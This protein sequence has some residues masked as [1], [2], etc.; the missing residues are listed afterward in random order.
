MDVF[1]RML[2]TDAEIKSKHI[3]ELEK[4]KKRLSEVLGTRTKSTTPVVTKKFKELSKDK[5]Y[6]LGL[7][8]MWIIW[9]LVRT[10]DSFELVGYWFE[11]WDEDS[12]YINM[13]IGPVIIW[14][15]MRVVKKFNW[16]N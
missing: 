3:Y 12:I 2:A 1:D 10:N 16:R 15:V 7:S 8:L 13:L 9:V 14:L 6:F 5:K 4:E 11:R